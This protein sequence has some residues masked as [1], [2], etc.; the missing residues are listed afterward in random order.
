MEIVTTGYMLKKYG[1]IND[2]KK[3]KNKKTAHSIKSKQKRFGYSD[4]LKEI[5]INTVEFLNI[6]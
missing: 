3:M 2:V 4:Q 6:K 1:K 5:L